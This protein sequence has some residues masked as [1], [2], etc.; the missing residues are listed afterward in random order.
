[1][2]LRIAALIIVALAATAYAQDKPKTE[3]PKAATAELAPASLPLAQADMQALADVLA[4]ARGYARSI[5]ALQE[6]LD[7]A[8]AE[9][10]RVF[11]R[12][13]AQHPDM[14]IDLQTMSYRAKVKDATVK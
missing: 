5:A 6:K 13:Q 4:D 9:A 12:A 10:Q 3:L 1:M 2:R 8:N 7:S 11:A 14:P